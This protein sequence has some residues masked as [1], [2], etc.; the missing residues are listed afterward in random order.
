MGQTKKI[1][2]TKGTD[3]EGL[4]CT[5]SSRLNVFADIGDQVTIIV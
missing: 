5:N 3:K 2:L 4:F 1:I